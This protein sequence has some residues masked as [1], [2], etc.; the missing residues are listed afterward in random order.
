[1]LVLTL[2]IQ[3]TK[4]S[5]TGTPFS[6]KPYLAYLLLM[7]LPALIYMSALTF[8]LGA[9][10]RRQ[11]AVALVTIAYALSVLFF[12]GLRYGG[13][14][15][16]GAFFAPI[17]YSDL[18][19]LGDIQKLIIQRLFYIGLGLALIGLSIE[20][21]PSLPQPLGW[22]WFGRSFVLIGLGIAVGLFF[23]LEKLYMNGIKKVQKKEKKR[24][25]REENLH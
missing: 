2:V 19:G 22:A 25:K 24:V 10:L 3:A 4:V 5:I 12:L 21:Y 11:T 8:C 6:L 23:F 18:M 14:Y 1:M 17:F 16:F 9:F 13:I 15:D 7:N 20:L